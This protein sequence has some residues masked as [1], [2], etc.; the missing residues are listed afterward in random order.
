M[1]ISSIEQTIAEKGSLLIIT[2]GHSMWPLLRGGKDP[3]CLK[4]PAILRKYDVVLF[5][6]DHA[7][8]VLH[9]IVAVGQDRRCLVCGD[10]ES[11]REW[12]RPEQVKAVMDGFYRGKTYISCGHPL[13]RIYVQ[14]V[15]A[16]YPLRVWLLC[17]R[18]LFAKK[19]VAG[20]K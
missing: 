12:I 18:A 6:R 1:L 5:R 9:R 16:A 2:H 14:L 19:T 13:Y 10:A 17:L 20:K 7:G 4:K 3:V 8:L 15:C 11:G